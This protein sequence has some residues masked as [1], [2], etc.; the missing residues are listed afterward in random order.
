MSSDRAPGAGRRSRRDL[1]E[2]LLSPPFRD[3]RFW[4]I[5][6]VALAIV[7]VHL[8]VDTAQDRGLISMPGFVVLL[9]LFLPVVYAGTA[10]G[11][12]GSLAISLESAVLVVPGEL[13]ATH[14]DL[15]RW[16]TWSMLATVLVCAVLIGDRFE[17]ER[18]Q[19]SQLLEQERARIAEYFEGHPLSWQH[20]LQMLPD[21]ICIVDELGCIRFVNERLVQLSGYERDELVGDTVER[22]VQADRRVE[23]AQ[24]RAATSVEGAVRPMGVG[25]DIVLERAGGASVPVDI[26]LQPVRFNGGRWTVAV[27]RDDAERREALLA[28]QLAEERERERLAAA[29]AALQE[30][31]E[32]FRLTFESNVDGIVLVDT[33]DR[34]LQANPAFCRMVGY[35]THELVGEGAVAITHPRDVATGRSAHARL[36]SGEVA[37]VNFTK[38][39]LHRDGRVIW[40][41][42]QKA[43]ARGVTGAIEYLVC[44]VRDVTRQHTLTSQLSRL[45]MQDPLTG[46]ANRRAF[47]DR[48]GKALVRR[49]ARN[50]FVAVALLDLD[51]FKG[52]NDALGHDVGDELLTAV[53]QRLQHAAR[54]GDTV[55]RFGGDEF[56]YLAEG[57]DSRAQA[58]ELAARLLAAVTET[59]VIRGQRVSQR[60]SVGVAVSDASSDAA[61]PDAARMIRHADIALYE[62]KRKGKGV[63]AMF[64]EDMRERAA[65]HYELRQELQQ[66]LIRSELRMHYQPIMSLATGRLSGFEALMRWHHAQRGSV[67]PDVFIPVA[68]QSDLIAELGTFALQQALAQAAGWRAPATDG[69]PPRV[70]VNLSPRQL[71]APGL[72]DQVVGLLE[73]SGVAPERLVLEVTESTIL[74]DPDAAAALVSDL[75]RLGVAF[76]LDDFGTGYSSLSSLAQLRPSLLKVDRSFV[77]KVPGTPQASA[78]LR[79]VVSLGHELG[80]AVVAEGIETAAQL[81]VVEGL[82][83]DFGQGYL[84]APALPGDEVAECWEPAFTTTRAARRVAE[85]A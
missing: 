26:L 24:V 54:A 66:A 64:T 30:S 74:S 45:A 69:L 27:V 79:A 9:A 77:S 33:E 36:M 31:E 42:I 15:A 11:L 29:A 12:A 32:R 39:Y 6:I 19:R 78:M 72:R 3:R 43:P 84:F 73:S 59:F 48:L 28:R 67:P 60:T 52:V 41:E 53:A 14:S 8:V 17:V 80:M 22:L 38:R 5:N 63:V 35:D 1:L 10:Y 2:N 20:L 23:H 56:L 47:E 18:V 68:E 34:L 37:Q 49:H 25:H 55:A 13:L 65:D 83:C 71:Y 7:L 21:G 44:S 40:V 76:A 70:A 16:A 62:A 57:L 61:Q 58:E 85:G 46:L 51:D 82:G 81:E 50:E 4:I 75:R